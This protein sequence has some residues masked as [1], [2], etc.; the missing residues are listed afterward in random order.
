MFIELHSLPDEELGKAWYQW[1]PPILRP[2]CAA[3]NEIKRPGQ[4]NAMQWKLTIPRASCS[5]P[6]YIAD[7]VRITPQ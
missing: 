1:C 4:G 6:E 5:L 3:S 2:D 7:S